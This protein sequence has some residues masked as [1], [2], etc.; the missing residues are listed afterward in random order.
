MG[1]ESQTIFFLSTNYIHTHIHSLYP[2]YCYIHMLNLNYFEYYR[3]CYIAIAYLLTRF[4][5]FFRY[6]CCWCCCLLSIHNIDMIKT[7]IYTRTRHT[8]H[9]TKKHLQ[10][11][12]NKVKAQDRFKPHIEI[13]IHNKGTHS[14]THPQPLQYSLLFVLFTYSAANYYHCWYFSV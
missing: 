2:L 13:Q 1:I 14:L 5:S 9:S 6:W 7:N 3:L 4:S 11:R 12:L 8:K 10:L